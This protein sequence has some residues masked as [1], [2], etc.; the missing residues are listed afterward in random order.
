MSD[1]F[2][3]AQVMSAGAGVYAQPAA[4]QSIVEASAYQQSAR[5]VVVGDL[6]RSAAVWAVRVENMVSATECALISKQ[7]KAVCVRCIFEA[8]C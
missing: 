6:Q 2:L 5:G 3:V 7:S 4:D 8:S 1:E